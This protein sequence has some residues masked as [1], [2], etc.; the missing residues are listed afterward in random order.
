MATVLQRRKVRP[1][2]TAPGPRPFSHRPLG[3]TQEQQTE[4]VRLSV[5]HL[6]PGQVEA[7]SLLSVFQ[8]DGIKEP[9]GPNVIRVGPWDHG[10]VWPTLG[11]WMPWSQLLDPS[12]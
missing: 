7:G 3:W 1:V 12:P 5:P 9:Q 11:W 4:G 2:G 10:Q 8:E 6:C